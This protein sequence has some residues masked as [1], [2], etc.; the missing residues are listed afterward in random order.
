[1]QIEEAAQVILQRLDSLYWMDM[2]NEYEPEDCDNHWDDMRYCVKANKY[3]YGASKVVFYYNELE[4]FVIKM[5]IIG[6]YDIDDEEYH[7]YEFA[8]SLCFPEQ[9]SWYECWDYCGVEA[10]TYA[11]LESH[12]PQLTKFFAATF[13]LGITINNIPVY[14]AQKVEETLLDTTEI[15]VSKQAQVQASSVPQSL[16]YSTGLDEYV[17]G[18]FYDN[19]IPEE[20]NMLL[21]FLAHKK[22]NDFHYGNIGLTK[23]GRPVIIDYSNFN[24]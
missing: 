14:I 11:Y 21:D 2:Y 8:R 13:I 24:S 10:E 4:Q 7:D 6:C 3:N 12:A 9:E 17:L 5:P 15:Q 23:T 20:V 18:L 19:Y 16:R 1:M 22:I